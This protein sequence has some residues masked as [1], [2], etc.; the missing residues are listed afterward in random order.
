MEYRCK[1]LFCTFLLMIMFFSG[2]LFAEGT[3]RALIIGID[4][5]LP[6]NITEVKSERRSWIN[7]DGCVNDAKSIKALLE[8][9]YGF[10]EAHIIFLSNEKATREGIIT[11]IKR[12]TE[13][14]EKGDLVVIYFAGHGSQ[15]RNTASSEADQ[16]DETIVPSDAYLG[17]ADIRD[18][19][20]NELFYQLSDK[21]VILTA[22]FD[23]CHSGSISRGLAEHEPKS[24]YLAPVPS[25]WV[26]DP[27]VPHDLTAKDV[28]IISAA[29]DEETAKEQADEHGDPHG[30]FTYALLRTLATL[31]ANVPAIKVIEGARAVI[32]YN[33]KSQEPVFEGNVKRKNFTLIGLPR[34]SVPNILTVAV[35][36][37]EDK[38]NITLQGGYVSG[39]RPDCKLMKVYY[40]DTVLIQVIRV[41][42]A[43]NSAAKVIKGDFTR[44]KPGDMFQVNQWASESQ[45]GLNVYIP[46]SADDY[47]V[48]CTL[49][50]TVCN[51]L[52]SCNKIRVITD[53]TA[54]D[55]IHTV[56]F[57]GKSWMVHKTT[58][59]FVPLGQL[60]S[61]SGICR[62]L[63]SGGSVFVSLPAFK[64]LGLLLSE[65]YKN[66]SAVSVTQNSAESD[67][68]LSGR[69][70]N[71]GLEYAYI[72]TT[73]S[74]VKGIT[75][76]PV[77]T[78]FVKFNKEPA[79][80]KKAAD[81]LA[82]YSSRIARLKAWLTLASPPDDGAF[83]YFLAL[84]NATNGKVVSSGSIIESE[85]YGL[86]LVKD[87][88]NSRNWDG[89]RRFVYVSS[90]DSRGRSSLMFPLSN[91]ENHFPIGNE[92]PDT[93]FLGRRQL[94]QVTPP[95]GYD[96]YI[97]LALDEQL[98]NVDIFNS[99]GVR[100]RGITSPLLKYLT[101]GG[102]KS[103]GNEIFVSPSS[104]KKQVV[105]IQSR[106]K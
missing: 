66:N 88:V 35:L 92:L 41:G 39:I 51:G 36:N 94:F 32:R 100:T 37:N 45:N 57:N 21:G 49:S 102:V 46:P 105:T 31:S 72:S 29:Q 40:P 106:G 22:L 91:V 86:I 78:N 9:K 71:D 10:E 38:D 77:R 8:S 80:L 5:Y 47:N 19:E 17:V 69:F 20:I 63:P 12:L 26:N 93:I 16:K 24:R 82:E 76:L 13:V 6:E 83:P 95:F 48:L 97:L 2:S 75:V 15:I 1:L 74:P 30:A 7:L 84:R 104:W 3:R 28:L 44:I 58:G 68:I 14:S 53:P 98:P 89:S 55:S 25:A 99:A 18:K 50:K 61:G 11:A 103:R 59:E 65:I 42:S 81:T 73:A 70:I 52:K 62:A 101:T 60:L 54:T 85:I 96:H 27:T 56:F 79:I 67:Y 64:S 34:E 90:V 43:N 23:S 33:G 87:P 4:I